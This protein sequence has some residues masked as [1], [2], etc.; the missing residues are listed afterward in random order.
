M[1]ISLDGI[2]SR[3][4]TAEEV[5]S[6]LEDIAMDFIKMKQREESNRGKKKR[7]RPPTY[8]W[9]NIRWS[10]MWSSLSRRDKEDTEE[11]L[12][13]WPHTQMGSLPPQAY[14]NQINDNKK[15]LKA[16]RRHMCSEEQRISEKFSSE[17]VQTR[18]RWDDKCHLLSKVSPENQALHPLYHTLCPYLVLIINLLVSPRR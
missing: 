8:L 13:K 15:I 16:D 5:I 12:K 10:N 4:D 9:Y 14:Y 1:K 3:L 2:N 6:E 18:R 11:Y 7:N 17:T